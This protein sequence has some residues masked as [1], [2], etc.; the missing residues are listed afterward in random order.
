MR[1]CDSS[2]CD[3]KHFA[4]GFCYSHYHRLWKSRRANAHIPIQE[5]D[6]VKRF[7]Q[8][9]Y[10]TQDGCWIWQGTLDP[11]GYPRFNY[12]RG[13]RWSYEHFIDSIPKGLEID[14]LCR[15]RACVNPEHLE[16]VTTKENQLRGDSVSGINARKVRC[17]R[18]HPFDE[19]NTYLTPDGRR[20]C[21][22]CRSVRYQERN[23]ATPD[24][25]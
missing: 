20:Q 10:Q 25:S 12:G 3:R 8:W 21:R 17:K 19:V 13:H 5:T 14:H 16:A 24:K 23:L 9:V 22:T 1:V 15:N 4:K 18:G 6:T 7:W 11:D 2:V